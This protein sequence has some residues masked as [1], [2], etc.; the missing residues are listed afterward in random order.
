MFILSTQRGIIVRL[1]APHTGV[2]LT[3]GKGGELMDYKLNLE[4]LE[5]RIAPLNISLGGEG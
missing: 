3:N 4:V 1:S 5:A 2:R